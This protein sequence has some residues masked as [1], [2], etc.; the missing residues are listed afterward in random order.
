MYMAALNSE[1]IET[2]IE[3]TMDSFERGDMAEVRES[4]LILF[5]SEYEGKYSAERDR[6]LKRVWDEGHENE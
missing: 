1:I 5:P 6:V 3:N 2:F 4:L